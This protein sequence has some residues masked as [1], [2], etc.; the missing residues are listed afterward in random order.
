MLNII[1][2]FTGG[3]IGAV[4]R[5]LTG[6]IIL[7][8]SHLSLPPA[9]FIVN[10]AGSFL[11]GFLYIFFI[12]KQELNPAIKLALTVGFCGGLTTFSTF[13]LELFEM[14]KNAHFIN[15]FLY[16]I[17]SIIICVTAVITGAYIAKFCI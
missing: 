13:S 15:A 14:I 8:Y 9:T 1:A 7:K 17:I 11:I 5:Y 3:G 4:I 2:I 6:I 16:V 10:V 12:E